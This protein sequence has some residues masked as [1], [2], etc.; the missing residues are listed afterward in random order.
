GLFVCGSFLFSLAGWLAFVW[1]CKPSPT[2]V[3]ESAQKTISRFVLLII[4][5]LP[6][7][8][9]WIYRLAS[10]IEAQSFFASARRIA[11]DYRDT[12]AFSVFANLLDLSILVALVA[13]YERENHRQRA[14]L[15]TLAAVVMCILMGSK[16]F[17]LFFLA[18]LFCVNWLKTRRFNWKT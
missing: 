12:A 2:V 14:W 9:Y 13:M 7:Y 1:P 15:A 11:V 18:S 5:S 4:V 17:I 8:C 6:I 10:G 16:G 3:S